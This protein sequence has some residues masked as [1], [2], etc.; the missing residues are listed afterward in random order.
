MSSKYYLPASQPT[1]Y[2]QTIVYL[3]TEELASQKTIY[4]SDLASQNTIYLCDPASQITIYRSELASQ[5]TIYPS[6]SKHYL[7]LR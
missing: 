1:I 5:T 3:R 2:L 4:R 7:P 6:V